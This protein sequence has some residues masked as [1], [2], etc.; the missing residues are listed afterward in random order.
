MLISITI[1]FYNSR[2]S[3]ENFR[4]KIPE[5]EKLACCIKNKIIK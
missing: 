3:L 2:L 1:P 5:T 4:T